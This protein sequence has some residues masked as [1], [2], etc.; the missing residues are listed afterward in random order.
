M[1]LK[2]G[3]PGRVNPAGIDNSASR[4]SLGHMVRLVGRSLEWLMLRDRGRHCA[5]HPCGGELDVDLPVKVLGKAALDQPGAKTATGWG[6]GA[7]VR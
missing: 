5:Q 4:V 1:D 2:P 6:D 7:Q 3:Q